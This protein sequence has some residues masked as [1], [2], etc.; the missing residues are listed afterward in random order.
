MIAIVG[1]KVE[2]NSMTF[3]PYEDDNMIIKSF[4]CKRALIKSINIEYDYQSNNYKVWKDYMTY[5]FY[6]LEIDNK[7]FLSFGISVKN[8][9][10]YKKL[11]YFINYI[12]FEDYLQDS[13]EVI[14][15][16]FDIKNILYGGIN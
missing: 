15:K 10:R 14:D 12:R 4:E 11:F 8:E 6:N 13:I 16:K 7:P 9:V 1:K 5:T 2:E 3:I